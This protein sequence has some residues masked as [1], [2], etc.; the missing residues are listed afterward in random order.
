MHLKN[1]TSRYF[2]N[3]SPAFVLLN[4][5]LDAILLQVVLEPLS[6]E[7]RLL[8]SALT[9]YIGELGMKAAQ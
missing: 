4:V 6:G 2:R 9:G 1:R 7:A 3:I 8:G 5:A